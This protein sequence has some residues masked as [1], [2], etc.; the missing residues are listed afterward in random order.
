M[1]RIIKLDSEVEA[2]LDTYTE[3]REEACLESPL[4]GHRGTFPDFVDISVKPEN[5]LISAQN[6]IDSSE[7]I[8]LDACVAEDKK[9]IRK[10]CNSAFQVEKTEVVLDIQHPRRIQP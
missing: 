1:K 4:C 2:E 3:I 6:H 9:I 7:Q 8:N 5:K 10:Q